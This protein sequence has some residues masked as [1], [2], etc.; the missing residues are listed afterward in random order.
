M[1]K[2]DNFSQT[3]VSNAELEQELYDQAEVF[4][5]NGNTVRNII[6]VHM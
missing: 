4:I 1:I 5:K 3:N 2:V 6:E